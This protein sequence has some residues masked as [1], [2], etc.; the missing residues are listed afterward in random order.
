MKRNS[1]R[2]RLERLEERIVPSA[3][4]DID[5]LRQFGGTPASTNAVDRGSGVSVTPSGLYVAG[6]T[7]GTTLPGQ[8]LVG[9]RVAAFVRKYD[10]DGNEVWTRQFTSTVSVQA[11]GVAADASG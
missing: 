1:R 10:T 3:P 9:D 5:W 4:G 6:Y 11:N 7:V 8:P 2:L